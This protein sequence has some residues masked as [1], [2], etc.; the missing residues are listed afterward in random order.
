[1]FHSRH[2]LVSLRKLGEGFT[3]IAATADGALTIGAMTPLSDIK[4][5]PEVLHHAPVIGRT[6]QHLSKT[7]RLPNVATVG[8][9]LA[10]A[11]P[12]MDLPP[13]LIAL[14]AT[15]SIAGAVRANAAC[16]LR[17]C[18]PVTTRPRLLRTS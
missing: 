6:M 5:S 3:R 9:A 16:R 1:M 4:H 13:V 18:S 17:T 14:G 12:H 7:S 15:I 8:G 10:H 11:D 2:R